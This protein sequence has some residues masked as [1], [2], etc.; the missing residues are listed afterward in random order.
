MNNWP[1]LLK[2]PTIFMAFALLA[3]T[4]LLIYGAN[5]SLAQSSDSVAPMAAGELQSAEGAAA[6]FG[7]SDTG[8]YIIQL[9]DP[10][11]PGYTGGIAGLAA[12]SPQVTGETRL[13]GNSPAVQAYISY[14]HGKQ[15]ELLA[16]MSAT[17]GRSVEPVFRYESAMNGLAIE[18]SHAEAIAVSQLPGVIAVFGDIEE[19]LAT[20]VGPWFLGAP[21]IWFGDTGS[22][23]ATRGEGTIVGIIDTGGN[24]DHPSFAATDGEGYTHTNPYGAGVYNGWCA[25][26]PGFCNDKLIGA[27]GLNPVGGNPADDN[28]HGS[29]TGSTAAG[30]IHDAVFDVGNDTFTLTVAGVA[31]RANVVHYKV[32]TPGCPQSA[33]V[34]AVN[35]AINDD[36]VDVLNYSISGVDNPWNDAVDIAF[37]NGFNA[38][39]YI[40]ASAG[41]AG[42]GPSTVAKTGPWNASTAASTINRII[43]HTVDVVSPT[44]PP[45]LQDM[46]AVPGDNVSI[47]ADITEEIRYNAA[48]ATGCNPGH[49]AGFFDDA[50]ALVIRGGCTFAEKVNNAAAAGAEAVVVFNHVGGPPISMGGLTAAMIPSV[51]ID[52]VNGADLR[53]YVIANPGAEVTINAGSALIYNDDWENVVAGFSSRGPSQ[54]EMLAPTFIAPGVN[55]LAAGPFGPDDYYFSQGTSMSSPHAAGAGAL[56]M[57]LNPTWSPAEVRSALALTANPDGFVKEDGA[58]PADWFDVGSGLLDLTAAGNIGLVMDETYD[59][60]VDAN[61]DIGG[62]PKT[63]NLPAFLNYNCTG[64]C[65]WTR[66]VTS[67]AQDDVTYDAVVDAPAGMTITVEPA[68]FAISPGESQVLTVTVDVDGMA[69]GSFAFA[70]VQLV[71]QPLSVPNELLNES[72]SDETFPPDGWATYWL[73]GAGTQQWTRVTATSNT[74]PASAHRRWSGTADG[75]QD[76]WLVTPPITATL[77]GVSLN[78]A[79]RGQFMADYVYSGV[80]AST[81]S[82]DPEDG[83]FVELAEIDD[84]INV[85]WRDVPTIDLSAYSGQPVCLAFRYSGTFAHSWWV[86]DVVVQE[87]EPAAVP[88][89]HMP[90]AVIPA[91]ATPVIDVN[92]DELSAAQPADE[93]TTQTLVIGNNGGVDLEWEIAEAPVAARLGLTLEDSDVPAAVEGG[94]PMSF[95]LDDGVGENAVGLTGG[96]QFLWFNRFTPN[97]FNYPITID[98]VDVMFG[99]PGSTGGINIGELVDIYLYEDEDGDPANG[100]THRASLHDQEVQAVDGVTWSSYTLTTPVTFDG[101]GDILIAV[102][103]RTAGVTPSTFPAVIDQTPPSQQRSWI[104]FGEVPADPPVMPM[105]TFAIIDSL[106]LPGNWMVRGFGTGNIPCDNPTDVPWLDADPDMGTT[107]PGSTT[108]VTVTFDSTGLAPGEYSALFCIE[109]NDPANPLVEVPVTLQVGENPSAEVDTT[110]ISITL[111]ANTQSTAT[112]TIGNTGEGDLEWD[113]ET[114]EPLAG[115]VPTLA[116]GLPTGGDRANPSSATAAAPSAILPTSANVLSGSWSEG[117]DDVDL[118]PGLGWAL[119]NNSQPVGTSGWFQGNPAVFPSH[120]GDPDSYIGANF[121]NTTGSNTISNWLLTPEITMNNGD[122]FSFWTNSPDSAWEDRLQV[123][124]STSGDS[125]DVG[126]TATS[127]GVFDTLLLDINPTYAPGGY[128]TSWTEFEV[129]ISGLAGPTN[130]RLA[131]RYFV[132]NGGPGGTNSDYIG[133]DTVEYVTA[134]ACATPSIISWLS[135]DPDSGVTAPGTSDDVTVTVDATGLSAGDYAAVLCINTND[136]DNMVIEVPVQVTVEEKAWIQVAHL[137]PFAMDPGTAVTVTLNG[138]PALTDFA[139]G[140]STGYIELD[141]GTYDVAVWPAGSS[142]PAITATVELMADT[143]YSVAAIGDGVNQPLALLALVDDNTAPA[144]G[145]FKIRLGHLAPFAAGG[146]TADIRLADGTPVLEGVEFGDVSGYLELPAGTYDLII[147]APGGSPTLINPDPVTFADGDIITA[148][149]TGDGSNQDLGVFAWPPDTVGFFLPLGEITP[150]GTTLY[151]PIII[152]N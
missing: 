96:A 148:F 88:A 37:L 111:S 101:P 23:T 79:D 109:S 65:S 82:C 136:P 71:P 50:I 84:S 72:F 7:V 149:A 121:N 130:G 13:D 21:S 131:F 46:A 44:T 47:T 60:F 11:V 133:I 41:N 110:P 52:N 105:P 128:P 25:T 16:D 86:D 142:S 38:G 78:F 73:E 74:P 115:S 92:P 134:T 49:P 27:Y 135:V 28:G 132:E 108:N 31:P 68:S 51:M 124:L 64:E 123:R 118:L 14:L 67:V 39:I 103:N 32:C 97:S 152:R 54:F 2:K 113:I 151:L 98:S 55:T 66:T 144:A 17:L 81:G 120:S 143:Y 48:N 93:I 40:A 59:N 140:D 22:G 117:F 147:T 150:P 99:Y 112:L 18:M 56:L 126:T 29:H 4:F 95:I 125:T 10:A 137:A 8:R 19:E 1:G 24:F 90:V 106:G 141:A 116:L 42:P 6:V 122:T 114:A 70:D 94:S 89:V 83:D 30:N 63:L 53:D 61:P 69:L 80:W 5:N 3:G 20:D 102:V 36:M 139:Y 57:A 15:D 58:T 127:V 77:A 9:E 75:F 33:S 26:N 107:G 12:T 35:H 85:V 43:A 100:A 62:D 119:I 129:T 76:D 145:N 146:A 34:A 138:A 91:F 104:G 45:E 87:F